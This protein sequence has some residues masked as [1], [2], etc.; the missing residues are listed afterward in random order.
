MSTLR[1]IS[2]VEIKS[3]I[4]YIIT[5]LVVLLAFYVHCSFMHKKSN[6]NLLMQIYYWNFCFFYISSLAYY[7]FISS[8]KYVCV[9]WLKKSRSSLSSECFNMQT[10]NIQI[11]IPTKTETISTEGSQTM[12]PRSPHLEQL[13][14]EPSDSDSKKKSAQLAARPKHN[15][16]L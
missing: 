10:C 12:A 3:K 11:A 9:L 7:T 4:L 15:R 5:Y 14:A 8:A 1:I 2:K 16:K 13:K 6:Q